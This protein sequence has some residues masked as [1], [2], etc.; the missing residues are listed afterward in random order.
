MPP[1]VARDYEITYGSFVVG[2]SAP[3]DDNLGP[4]EYWRYKKGYRAG[5]LEFGF[6]VQGTSDADFKSKC[7]TAVAAFREP[8]RDLVFKLGAVEIIDARHST[9]TAL[10]TDPEII[11]MGDVKD[12][13]RTRFFQVRI[14]FGLPADNVSTAGR[15]EEM[16]GLSYTPARR[17]RV[18]FSGTYTAI[19]GGSATAR[20]QYEDNFPA[21]ATAVLAAIGGTFEL[22]EEP[23][24]QVNDTNKVCNYTCVYDQILFS[25]GGSAND[26]QII[27]QV[28]VIRRQKPAP[29]DTPTARR[30]AILGV[31]YSAWIDHTLTTNLESKWASIRSWIVGVAQA[32]YGTGIV[33][34]TDES[35]DFDKTDNRISATM[36]LMGFSGSSIIEQRITAERFVILGNVLVP[37]W[38]GDEWHK[39]QH[40]GHAEGK[41]TVTSITRYYGFVN[42]IG[43]SKVSGM[44]VGSAGGGAAGVF[45]A[46]HVGNGFPQGV[47]VPDLGFFVGP[48]A[49]FPHGVGFGGAPTPGTGGSG[50]SGSASNVYNPEPPQGL[51]FL[52]ISIRIAQT[53]IQLGQDA[54]TIPTTDVQ[55]VAEAELF[56]PYSSPVTT[57]RGYTYTKQGGS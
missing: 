19:P 52:P 42:V 25:K 35:V 43:K 37:I 30:L 48:L 16:V 32:T 41:Q 6:V 3:T 57:T 27:R 22:G 38:T 40:H 9:N 2:G 18:T 50:S 13:K 44:G 4:H 31:N 47:N 56:K 29:G 21:H 1:T 11:K 5:Y 28:V 34:L 17:K 12:T 55:Q 26:A 53:P 8:R 24:V 54:W 14:E 45:V 51:K 33:A 49:G 36:T 46:G 7:D 20:D 39:Y 23:Q 10:D 15:R